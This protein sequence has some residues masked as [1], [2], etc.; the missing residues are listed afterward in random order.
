ML[1]LL[2]LFLL[3]YFSFPFSVFILC[4]YTSK[5]AHVTPCEASHCLCF[6]RQWASHVL[7][8]DRDGDWGCEEEKAKDEH[9]PEPVLS[10]VEAH[11]AFQTVKSF[12]YTHSGDRDENILNI[13]KA[14]QLWVN[15]F[16]GRNRRGQRT[17]HHKACAFYKTFHSASHSDRVFCLA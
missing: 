4:T 12:F 1:L 10:F 6:F 15:V 16:W 8:D 7:C 9:E 14:N 13:E 5:L 3:L 17:S 11:I 2:L